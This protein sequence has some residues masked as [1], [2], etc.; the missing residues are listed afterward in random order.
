PLRR[1][2]LLR[3]L[4]WGRHLGV[5]ADVELRRL[6]EDPLFAVVELVGRHVLE[7]LV[8]RHRRPARPLRTRAPHHPAGAECGAGIPGPADLLIPE[9]AAVMVDDLTPR[10]L[11]VVVPAVLF[12]LHPVTGRIGMP[13]LGGDGWYPD[14]AEAVVLDAAAVLRAHAA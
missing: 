11:V 13:A 12:G 14:L 3:D 1:G 10:R 8:R 5:A 6:D 7:G 9:P 4:L 2:E